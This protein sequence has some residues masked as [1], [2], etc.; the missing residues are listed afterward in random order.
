MQRARAHLSGQSLFIFYLS[1][2]PARSGLPWHNPNAWQVLDLAKDE[3]AS[4][5][6]R[7]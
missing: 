6:A 7:R 2:C 3:R 5:A 4:Q 1:A